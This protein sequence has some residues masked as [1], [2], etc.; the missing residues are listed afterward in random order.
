MF[1]YLKKNIF[2]TIAA[3][4]FGTVIGRVVYLKRENSKDTLGQ[5]LNKKE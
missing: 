3:S 4:S 2:V 1:A 5:I